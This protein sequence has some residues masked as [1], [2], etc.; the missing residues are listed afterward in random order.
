[1]GIVNLDGS[2]SNNESD[3]ALDARELT[4]LIRALQA[5]DLTAGDRAAA[6]SL[7]DELEA[8]VRTSVS[9]TPPPTTSSG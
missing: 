9:E 3:L 6:R 7:L 5:K 8:F 2:P 1:M 4:D